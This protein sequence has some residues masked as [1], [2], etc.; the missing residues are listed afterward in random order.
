MP[1]YLFFGLSKIAKKTY[2]LFSL[3]N[4]LRA[5]LCPSNPPFTHPKQISFGK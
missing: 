3:S 5:G 2:L 4:I 1:A